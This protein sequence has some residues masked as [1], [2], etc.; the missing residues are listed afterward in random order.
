[1]HGRVMVDLM[2]V[3]QV[4]AISFLVKLLRQRS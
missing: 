4:R 3:V 2:K 1:M